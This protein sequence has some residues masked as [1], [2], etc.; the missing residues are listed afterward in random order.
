MNN[1]KRLLIAVSLIVI[2]LPNGKVAQA[3]SIGP[4]KTQIS[5]E[6]VQVE[7][8]QEKV[9]TQIT[10]GDLANLIVIEDG[11]TFRVEARPD[12]NEMRKALG[13]EIS[14]KLK[15]KLVAQGEVVEDINPLAEYE[16]LSAESRD[17]FDKLRLDFLQNVAKTLHKVDFA[18]GAGSVVG[19]SFTFLKLKAFKNEQAQQELS[20][21]STRSFKE[22]SAHAIEA[23]LKGINYKLYNQAPLLIEANEF[24]LSLSVGVAA[25]LGMGRKGVGYNQELGLSFAYNK[26][27][28]A[29]VFEIFHNSEKF[30]NS[31]SFV[32][33][34]GVIGKLGMTIGVRD[35]A[36]IIKGSSFYPSF[37][38]GFS[39]TSPSYFYTGASTSFGFP[40]SPFADM[41]TFTNDFH[42]TPLL[43]ITFSPVVKGFI[44]IQLGPVHELPKLIIAKV[45]DS[46]GQVREMINYFQRGKCGQ[47]FIN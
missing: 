47:V 45:G 18:L 37:I 20:E 40:P 39:S 4:K 38:P 1:I 44:R 6:D 32:S 41:L 21:R 10:E 17:K 43:R 22:K 29:F 5:I 3:N 28:K 25:E 8:I 7:V 13:L 26:A 42:R 36:K 15:A 35:G 16:S 27:D 30:N 19:D 9:S 14:E 46:L 2:L 31:R 12:P 11:P 23:A 33:L 24:G 34:L